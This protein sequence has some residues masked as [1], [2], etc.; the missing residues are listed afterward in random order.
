[1]PK[2]YIAKS[3]CPLCKGDVIGNR[4][5][6]YYC[7]RCNVLFSEEIIRGGDLFGGYKY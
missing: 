1:M 4:E 3:G 6:K 7:K 5:I 2:I